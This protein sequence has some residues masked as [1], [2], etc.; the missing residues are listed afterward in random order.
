MKLEVLMA[1][2]YPS[3]YLTVDP[4]Q[5]V[6]V[7]NLFLIP[8]DAATTLRACAKEKHSGSNSLSALIALIGL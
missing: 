7:E 6:L 8:A 4:F 2:P 3:V 5:S 1:M